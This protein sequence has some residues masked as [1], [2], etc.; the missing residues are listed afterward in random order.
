MV[1]IVEIENETDNRCN[2]SVIMK[3][4]K[5]PLARETHELLHMPSTSCL[6]ASQM[7]RSVLVQ[8]EI[9]RDG[10]LSDDQISCQI[11]QKTSGLHNLSHSYTHKNCIWGSLQFNNKIFLFDASSKEVIFEMYVPCV[12]KNPE[13]Q[14][15]CFLGG[16]HCVR[17]C[18]STGLVWVALKGAVGCCP[19]VKT[20]ENISKK[21]RE[22]CNID[23]IKESMNIEHTTVPN[24]FAVWCIDPEQYDENDVPS[25]GG[26]IYPCEPS[27]PMMEIDNAG[28]CWIAQDGS[29][30]IMSICDGVAKQHPVPHPNDCQMYI[31]GPAMVLSPNGDIWCCLLGGDGALVRITDGMPICL[32]ETGKPEWSK[33]MRIIHFVF[34]D[35]SRCMYAIS[36]DLLDEKSVN[37]VVI[38]KFGQDWKKIIARRVIP[39]PTQDCSCHRIVLI[40]TDNTEDRSIVVSEMASSKIFQMKINNIT[41]YSSLNET[42]LFK[43]D[44]EYRSYV[45]LPEIDGLRV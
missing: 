32:Y 25:Y 20:T 6:F 23:S 7:S 10:M 12:Y 28:N 11:G 41:D 42:I 27:P 43:N 36:S 45:C 26:Q 40:K 31:T 21:L 34:D 5:L 4:V 29:T 37:A 9:N 35:V 24:G 38:L 39:L 8:I 14:E 33:Q 30:K 16:P 22:C 19:N 15:V 1:S 3:E 44:F 18:P 13:T 2:K 17:E